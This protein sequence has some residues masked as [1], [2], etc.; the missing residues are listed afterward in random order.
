[1]AMPRIGSI[2]GATIIAPM[3]TAGLLASNPNVAITQEPS[4]NIK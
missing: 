2:K 3:I 1:M 4:T